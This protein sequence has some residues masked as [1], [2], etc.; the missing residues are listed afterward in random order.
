[1]QAPKEEEHNTWE[2]DS[3]KST[4]AAQENKI[5]RTKNVRPHIEKKSRLQMGG[6]A[7]LQ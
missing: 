7:R 1:L 5:G 2:K 3:I 4:G 6:K